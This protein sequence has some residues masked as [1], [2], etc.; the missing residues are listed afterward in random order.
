MCVG[1]PGVYLLRNPALDHAQH[2]RGFNL[3]QRMS[4]RDLVNLLQT[5]AAARSG[6]M[7]RHKDRMISPWRLLPIIPRKRRRQTLAD[8][9]RAMPHDR[10]QSPS[11]DVRAFAAD[12][13]ELAPEGND[14]KAAEGFVDLNH[15]SCST[16]KEPKGFHAECAERRRRKPP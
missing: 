12:E 13:P 9:L 7:L 10:R 4:L 8:E 6:R 3:G 2:I 5:S 11:L 16:K 14:G 1:M 15:D